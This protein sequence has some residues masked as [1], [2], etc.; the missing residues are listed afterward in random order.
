MPSDQTNTIA[1]VFVVNFVCQHDI[2]E[3]I[4]ED[5]GTEFFSKIFTSVCKLLKIN[6]SPFWPQI[7]SSLERSH[8]II[9][10]E[11]LLHYVDKTFSNYI[12]CYITIRVLR[13]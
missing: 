6:S 7:N 4:F 5:Q 9:L 10:V 8:Q 11:Y 12:G 13:L 3:T 1:E 2:P